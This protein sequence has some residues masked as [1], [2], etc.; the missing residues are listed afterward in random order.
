MGA[1]ENFN[2]SFYISVEEN[3]SQRPFMT[4]GINPNYKH[5]GNLAMGHL[6]K[7]FGVKRDLIEIEKVN[8]G[9]L[10]KHTFAGDD[11][12][13]VIYEKEKSTIVNG[14]DSFEP[15]EMESTK[16]KKFLE[17]WHSSYQNMKTMKFQG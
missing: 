16:I 2:Y 9:E 8:N 17:D 4:F 5:L 15:F 6:G 1:Y 11:W 12:C 13:I 3:G 14:M 10:D 7:S